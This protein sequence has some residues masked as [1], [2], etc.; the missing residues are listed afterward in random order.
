MIGPRPPD[1]GRLQP[2]K[3]GGK[4]NF[5]F[6]ELCLLRVSLSAFP[7]ICYY[8]QQLKTAHAEMKAAE[9]RF[10]SVQLA[11]DEKKSEMIKVFFKVK[12]IGHLAD[13]CSCKLRNSES[14]NAEYLEELRQ[15]LNGLRI[16]EKHLS[17]SL[18]QKNEECEKLFH[19]D[20]NVLPMT[21]DLRCKYFKARDQLVACRE[22]EA[23][24]FKATISGVERDKILTIAT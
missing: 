14:A 11:R 23:Q 16:K 1:A 15:E 24:S 9:R 4:E 10:H 7:D 6:V 2:S 5:H 13:E 12:D 3:M 19:E 22:L 17:K 21:M 8:E 20:L 18:A